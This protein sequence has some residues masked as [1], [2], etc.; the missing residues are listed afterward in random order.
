[1]LGEILQV[2]SGRVMDLQ[3]AAVNVSVE[4]VDN[5]LLTER[6]QEQVYAAIR[7]PNHIGRIHAAADGDSIE[8]GAIAVR[9][10]QVTL[11]S[12]ANARAIVRVGAPLL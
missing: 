4:L 9:Q 5:G 12:E 11:F 7:K 8:V 6:R 2:K 10:F 3:V 1:M